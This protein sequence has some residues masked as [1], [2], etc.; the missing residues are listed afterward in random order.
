MTPSRQGFDSDR[1]RQIGVLLAIFSTIGVNI[2]ANT[3]RLGGLTM[4][5]ITDQFFSDVQ[6]IPAGYAFSIW[7]LIYLGLIGF[8][9]YQALPNQ[10]QDPILRRVDYLLIM[11]CIAQI[12]WVILFHYQLFVLSLVA[13]LG[14]LIPLILIYQVLNVGIVPVSRTER[15]LVHIPMSVYLAW[16]TIATVLNVAFVLHRLDWDGWGVS[17]EVWTVVVLGISTAIAATI[18]AQRSD[19]PYTMVVIWALVA[20][21]IRQANET[22]ISATAT[23][24]AVALGLLLIVD[25]FGFV[26]SR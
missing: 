11:A 13:M 18:A 3:F 5:E 1:L 20:I 21:A 23:G 17:T 8:G 25:E 19:T 6:I 14:I 9:I 12:A 7:G 15:W 16:I 22:L 24:M 4:P 10:R 2:L 26:D